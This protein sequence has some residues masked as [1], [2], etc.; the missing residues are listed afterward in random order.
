MQGYASSAGR[1]NH[2]KRLPLNGF[3]FLLGEN[4][5][6]HHVNVKAAASP[7]HVLLYFFSVRMADCGHG[8]GNYYKID[9]TKSKV[10]MMGQNCEY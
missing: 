9:I 10:V 4:H 8:G 6:F 2:Q 3:S 1:T 7:K 5:C